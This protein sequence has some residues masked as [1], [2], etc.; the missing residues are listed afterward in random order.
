MMTMTATTTT[1]NPLS[2]DYHLP[3]WTVTENGAYRH[4]CMAWLPDGVLG[5]KI[6]GFITTYDGKL[7]EGSSQRVRI[8]LD[9]RSVFSFSNRDTVPIE[10]DITVRHQTECIRQLLHVSVELMPRGKVRNR[11]AFDHRCGDVLVA[12][13]ESIMALNL[14]RR[15]TDRSPVYTDARV[16]PIESYV[17]ELKL[18]DPIHVECHNVGNEG[19]AFWVEDDFPQNE[20]YLRYGDPSSMNFISQLAEVT[21]RSAGD[22]TRRLYGVRFLTSFQAINESN[23]DP[24]S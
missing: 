8:L 23:Q 3:T 15:F 1:V 18:A 6:A 12:F 19:L 7:L 10:V 21:H 24:A 17:D 4:D 20:I 5:P 2:A 11:E 9:K 16:W 13:R 22:G 14:E